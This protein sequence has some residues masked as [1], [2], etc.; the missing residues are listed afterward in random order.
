MAKFVGL[1]LW[2]VFAPAG[3]ALTPGDVLW[4]HS[5]PI[6]GL[7]GR[8]VCDLMVHFLN[9]PGTAIVVTLMVALAVYLS[10]T[11][12]FNTAREWLTEHLSF[13]AWISEKWMHFRSRRA[14]A[15]IPVEMLDEQGEVFGAKREK[16]DAEARKAREK[17][18]RARNSNTLLSGLFGWF[19][20]F[21]KRDNLGIIPE[22]EEPAEATPASMWEAMPRMNVDA[23]PV[24]ALS[25]AAAAAAPY[26]QALAAAA[27][28]LPPQPDEIEFAPPSQPRLIAEDE[29]E[30]FSFVTKKEGVPQQPKP[31]PEAPSYGTVEQVPPSRT[32]T[33]QPPRAMPAPAAPMPPAA[34]IPQPT[35]GRRADSDIKA[36]AITAKSVR[37]YK[38]PSSSLLYKAE[39]QVQVREDALREEAKVLVEKC[40]RIWRRRPGDPDQSRS[41]RHHV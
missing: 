4:R 13:V 3:V 34:A 9:V 39:E 35:F 25:M 7:S 22:D 32:E 10:T 8:L 18:E 31:E 5:L 28:P 26:A 38:L 36:V 6:G 30:P 12:S 27:A 24:T 15:E 40:A 1:G 17:A 21:G 23:A 11:F 37:G 16:L 41:G 19:S 29:E 14:G 33:F 2:V 20:R